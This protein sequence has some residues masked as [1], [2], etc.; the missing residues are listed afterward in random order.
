MKIKPKDYIVDTKDLVFDLMDKIGVA[1]FEVDFDGE[2]DD[3]QV[4]E[5]SSF[6]PEKKSVQ[7]KVD[8]LLSKSVEGSR[9]SDGTRWSNGSSETLWK[10][11]VTLLEMIHSVCYET[12]EQVCDGWEN[13]DGSRGTFNFDVKKRKVRLDFG[14]RVMEIQ[15]SEYDF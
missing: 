3:G 1:S 15:T 11:N 9:V 13:N 14:V 5:P 6:L 7:K 10:E 4:G 2:G 12:L 8:E